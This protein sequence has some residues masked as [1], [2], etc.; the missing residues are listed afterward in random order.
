MRGLLNTKQVAR[1]LGIYK[2]KVY[3]LAK[4]ERLPCTSVTGKSVFPKKLVDEWIEENSLGVVRN[5]GEEERGF[6]LA[7]GS[8]DPSLGILR[9]LYTSHKT[10]GSLFTAT[11]GSSAGLTAIRDAVAGFALAHLLDPPTGDYNL[12]FVQKT[13]PSGVA[14]LPLFHRE[15]GL[16]LRAG[17]PL[18]LGTLANLTRTRVRM[19][20]RQSGG[21]RR[22]RYFRIGP[23][24]R[25]E[26]EWK[27]PCAV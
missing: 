14:V 2:K 20:N 21:D 19:I 22:I 23:D 27:Q 12:Q 24:H 15:A 13:I 5:K 10:P 16:L 25:A 26:L 3:Y 7:A 4:A 11:V 18:G 17:N 8:D 9:G 1:Y 6:L